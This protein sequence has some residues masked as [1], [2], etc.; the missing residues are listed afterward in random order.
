MAASVVAGV[1]NAAGAEAQPAGAAL[2]AAGMPAGAAAGAAGAG[3]AAA[4]STDRPDSGSTQPSSLSED[5]AE[6]EQQQQQQQQRRRWRQSARHAS[7]AGTEAVPRHALQTAAAEAEGEG[8]QAVEQHAAPA[9]AADAAAA[10]GASP[11]DAAAPPG[12]QPWHGFMSDKCIMSV[13]G[14]QDHP[15]EQYRHRVR[16]VA[17]ACLQCLLEV[18]VGR[19]AD[20]SNQWIAPTSAVLLHHAVPVSAYHHLCPNAAAPSG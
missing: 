6:S 7:E 19:E 9:A 20:G 13:R 8:D 5:E 18:R 10:G 12:G 14:V 17:A 4:D 16:C 2:P 11:P 3:P 1:L 15:S